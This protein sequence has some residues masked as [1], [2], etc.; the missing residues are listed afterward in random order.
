MNLRCIFYNNI[1]FCALFLW[2][3]SNV[4]IFTTINVKI[5]LF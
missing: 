4:V 3:R 2:V 5:G 1:G